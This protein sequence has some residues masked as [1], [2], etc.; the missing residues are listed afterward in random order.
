[1]YYCVDEYWLYFFVE[2][3][4]YEVDLMIDKLGFFVGFVFN[5]FEFWFWI[6]W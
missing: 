4:N 3:I 6:F 2:D 1:M 5:I